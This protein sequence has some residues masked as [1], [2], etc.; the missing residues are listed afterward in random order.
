MNSKTT[1]H[2]VKP[3]SS[4]IT[5]QAKN[6]V[7]RREVDK[8][9]G[10]PLQQPIWQPSLPETITATPP[11]ANSGHNFANVSVVSPA[12][13]LVQPKLTVGE[14][15]NKYEQ[16]ADRVADTVMRMPEPD[17]QGRPE[18][19]NKAGNHKIIQTKPLAEQI[20]PLIQ[21]QSTVEEDD[22][23]PLQTK[24]LIQRQEQPENE[25]KEEI[26][27]AKSIVQRQTDDEKEGEEPVQT[28]LLIQ[29]Q[30]QT[31]DDEDSPLQA[32][33][34]N[35]KTPKVNSE[36][37][38]YIK[39]IRGQG[40]PLSGGERDFFETRFGHNFGRVRIHSDDRAAKAARQIKAQ[41]FT[42]GND[43]FFAANRYQP[44]T[45][46][47][48]QL[49]AHELTHTVQQTGV[50]PQENVARPARFPSRPPLS[51]NTN[52]ASLMTAQSSSPL[53]INSVVQGEP[54]ITR[55][56]VNDNAPTAEPG[57][58]QA[59]PQAAQNEQITE[60][61]KLTVPT[62]PIQSNDKQEQVAES[63]PAKTVVP[64][65]QSA[66]AG[67]TTPAPES[68]TA[69]TTEPTAA[70][71]ESKDGEQKEGV[72]TEAG[73]PTQLIASI[74]VVPATQSLDTYNRSLGASQTALDK[75]RETVSANLPKVKTP[76][77]LTAK[78]PIKKKPF[79][80]KKATVPET[81]VG[82]KTGASA[83]PNKETLILT[84]INAKQDFRTT[85][86]AILA[87]KSNGGV[88]PDN[89]TAA[90]Q[91]IK[92][93]TGRIPD[94]LGAR[95]VVNLTGEADPNLAEAYQAESRQ[96]VGVAKRQAKA[97]SKQDFGEK[98]I[99]PAPD[100]GVIESKATLSQHK[101]AA[102]TLEP[103]QDIPD[104]VRA[105]IDQTMG[106][107]LK[108]A[109]QME[110][111]TYQGVRTK[112]EAD[113]NKA[114]A[115][116]QA[117]IEALDS[118]TK[119]KQIEAQNKAKVQV[120]DHRKEWN[121]EID[122][123]DKEYQTKSSKATT[124]EK[125]KIDAAS[126]K[127]K[128]DVE[129]YFKTAE[130]DSAQKKQQAETKTEKEK[131]K[132]EKESKGFLS[133]AGAIFGD[134]I[135][136]IKNAVSTIFDELKKAV[137][138]I[139]DQAKKLAMA[140]IESA[141]KTIVGLIQGLGTVLKGV[142]RVVFAAFPDIAKK[143][144]AKIESAVESATQAVNVAAASLKKDVTKLL[145]LLG[146]AINDILSVV[147]GAYNFALGAMRLIVRG[148]FDKLGQYIVQS[149]LKLIGVT[150]AGLMKLLGIT[151]KDM[152]KIIANPV[153]FLGN[154]VGAVKSG[155]NKFRD[156]SVKHL[157]SGLVGWLF[158]TFA[159]AG[160]QLPTKFNLAG[161]FSFVAQILGLTYDV[162]REKMVKRLGAKGEAIVSAFEK[163]FAFIKDFIT[164]GPIALWERVKESLGNLKEILFGSLI[165]WLRNTIIVKA[166]TKL[167]AFFNPVGAI[168]QAIQAIYN[169]V[170]FFKER[171]E[172][173]KS[174]AQ[175]V[176][177]SI[178]N[179][180]AGKVGAA[181]SLIEQSLASTIPII[182]AFLARLLGLGGIVGKVKGVIKKIKQPIDVAVDK[183]IGWLVKM[184]RK[185]WKEIK[186]IVGKL[187]PKQNKAPLN[188]VEQQHAIYGKDAAREMAN[189]PKKPKS[190]EELRKE[191]QKQ[192]KTLEGKYNS[193]LK[194]SVK[195]RIIFQ[196]PEEDK[197]DNNLDFHVHI[198]PNDFDTDSAVKWNFGSIA[199]DVNKYG[200]LKVDTE[201][202]RH[203]VPPKGLLAWLYH[204]AV[205]A[206]KKGATAILWIKNLVGISDK[207]YDPGDP[208]AAIKINKHTHITKSGKGERDLW[209]AHWGTRTAQEVYNR[210][211]AKEIRTIS[212]SSFEKLSEEDKEEF[213]RLEKEAG[214]TP[215]TPTD[216]AVTER[217]GEV[218]STQFFHT[219]LNRALIEEKEEKTE[220]ADSFKAELGAVAKRAAVQ[221]HLAVTVALEKSEDDGTVGERKEAEK[222]LKQK[223]K[224]TWENVP[225]VK[226]LDM[227]E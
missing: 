129:G 168:I 211:K 148:E 59:S 46:T 131:A 192:A 78:E 138:F 66:P 76:T 173:I 191:K 26:A 3:A 15:N 218:V 1:A 202:P 149:A 101:V 64:A 204:Q 89:A 178:Q 172:Q 187:V 39:S 11:P 48:R 180:A 73:N 68:I 49:L 31:E 188:K 119:A 86:R 28:K 30:A 155:A 162:L 52:V 126:T 169:V 94:T 25:D 159:S 7:F 135:D 190:Y 195:M 223:S 181:A 14:P 220:S 174:F 19:S 123:V 161:M 65:T 136:S 44:N 151:E 137:K 38:D 117:Q 109:L 201:R 24:L 79:E 175:S 199:P 216:G 144:N 10:N 9:P 83:D 208:L 214:E 13:L 98:N 200:N 27:Q 142:V 163:T 2:S 224:E 217:A 37:E 112:Q 115:E 6:A 107:N 96:H 185:A 227:F 58:G 106:A 128:Q 176:F 50:R 16:Q 71:P 154:L 22:E 90:L 34:A 193:K 100:D 118:D 125:G 145:D 160:I 33:T 184:A 20:T 91:S 171:W 205:A 207:T 179:I 164:R 43:I 110:Q 36:Q 114:E 152:Q 194:R 60:P 215:L 140:A 166:I 222:K 122:K 143:I 75:E 153:G 147:Q 93:G 62:E 5:T 45:K 72:K 132:G 70:A 4:S 42:V 196:P 121:G 120:T 82:T 203:H 63:Q 157:T 165:E 102:E 55:K 219:E 95:P 84:N 77:G 209:R 81:F 177:K 226:D 189:P 32:K 150:L 127:G 213:R 182:I 111:T 61:A 47:G 88:D 80:V 18:D 206:N 41:A 99:S 116:N 141:R 225:G 97:Q 170:M 87:A 133:R 12:P 167:V 40:Q 124:D 212:R 183:V 85:D 198:G 67:P 17:L 54:L 221:S 92:L 103:T 186:K 130:T 69:S 51:T 146:S 53:G 156:N 104:E 158:G 210:M 139:F 74:T 8:Q 56:A 57:G 29:K 105:D 108:S 113:K 134:I 23:E 197:K 35:S 21:R